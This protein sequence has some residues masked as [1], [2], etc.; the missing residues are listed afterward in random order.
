MAKPSQKAA[1]SIVLITDTAARALNKLGGKSN[2]PVS[3]ALNK[4]ADAQ[5]HGIGRHVTSHLR[6]VEGI[7]A[8]PNTKVLLVNVVEGATPIIVGV[9]EKGALVRME[10]NKGQ[11]DKL[12]AQSDEL[13]VVQKTVDMGKGKEIKLPPKV[14]MMAPGMRVG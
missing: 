11:M 1:L 2:S 7:N 3:A 12:K 6:A 9:M 13:A 8:G 5:D 10:R 14:Q 4:I